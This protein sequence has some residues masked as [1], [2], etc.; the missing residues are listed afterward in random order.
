MNA[1]QRCSSF[2]CFEWLRSVDDKA[3]PM[4]YCMRRFC[5]QQLTTIQ[6]SVSMLTREYPSRGDVDAMRTVG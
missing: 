3:V 5:L 2:T 6:N 4:S 1:E